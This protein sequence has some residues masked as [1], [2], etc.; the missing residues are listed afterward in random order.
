M[1]ESWCELKIDFMFIGQN[2]GC[3]VC[4]GKTDK[5]NAK[6]IYD[7][8]VRPFNEIRG[9]ELRW[10]F[11]DYGNMFIRSQPMELKKRLHE[12]YD[13]CR[14]LAYSITQRHCIPVTYYQYIPFDGDENVVGRIYNNARRLKFND[15]YSHNIFIEVVSVDGKEYIRL[16][17]TV[18]SPL[19][20]D[21]FLDTFYKTLPE[22]WFE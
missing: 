6:L 17:A 11:D 18:Y 3:I 2:D 14:R 19:F 9:E 22:R 5:L 8:H 12:N 13:S 16:S 21:K 10:R 15:I 4:D 1:V 20:I 7:E